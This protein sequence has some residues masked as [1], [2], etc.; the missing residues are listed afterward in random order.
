MQI[1]RTVNTG[2]LGIISYCADCV[3]CLIKVA[4]TGADVGAVESAILLNKMVENCKRH[5]SNARVATHP[6]KSLNLTLQFQCR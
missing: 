2:V 6:Q 1:M 4:W 3:L 5:L